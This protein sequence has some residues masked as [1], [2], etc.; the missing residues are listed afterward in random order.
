MNDALL[1]VDVLRGQ[2][3]EPC[4]HIR[5]PGAWPCGTAATGRPTRPNWPQQQV[6]LVAEHVRGNQISHLYRCAGCGHVRST[7]RDSDAYGQEVA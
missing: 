1:L 3:E 2:A 4:F 7:N 5:R 6:N